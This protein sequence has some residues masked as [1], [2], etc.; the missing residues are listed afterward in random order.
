MNNKNK[1]L[2]ISEDR[3]IKKLL[4]NLPDI[5]EVLFDI[6]ECDDDYDMDK[7][8]IIIY[9]VPYL[10][11]DRLS[12]CPVPANIVAANKPIILFSTHPLDC[13]DCLNSIENR[14]DC[15]LKP[16][17]I[18]HIHDVIKSKLPN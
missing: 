6:N 13:S 15:F 11:L 16:L 4:D 5:N 9:D 18:I 3:I 2:L 8:S 7:I 14:C 10:G 12:F 17:D 1:I